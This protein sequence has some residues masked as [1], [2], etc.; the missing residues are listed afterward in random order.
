MLTPTA[1]RTP[2]FL[3]LGNHDHRGHFVD[4]FAHEEAVAGAVVRGTR[5]PIHSTAAQ[6]RRIACV[7]E[8]SP[9]RLILLDSLFVV[10]VVS[11]FLGR[12]QRDWLEGYLTQADAT[13]TVIGMHHDLGQ[14]DQHLLD[15]DRFLEIIRPHRNVKAVLYGHSHRLRHDEWEGIHLFNLPAVGYSFDAQPLG[16]IDARLRAEGADFTVRAVA[17]ETSQDGRTFSLAWRSNF[18]T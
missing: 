10:N 14:G 9:V 4:V 17:G 8:G 6:R 13:P 7:I 1:Q 11:G 5:H 3:T 15:T 18:R 12:P 2:I 16:W